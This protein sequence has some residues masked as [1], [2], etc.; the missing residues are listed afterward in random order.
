MPRLA[1]ATFVGCSLLPLAAHAVSLTD[2]LQLM[3][4]PQLVSDYRSRGL[5]LTLGDPAAQLEAV[6]MHSSG[7]Y[8]GVWTSNVDFGLNLKT[9]LEQD[10]YAGYFSQ[11]SDDISLDVGYL[12]YTYAKEGQLN[13]SEVYAVLKAY[14]F[15]FASYYSNDLKSYIGDDQDTL[16]TYLGYSQAL[17]GEVGLKL[18]YGRFDFKD[19]VFIAGNG[20]TRGDYH[21]WEAR[22]T[23]N[24][25]GLDWGVAYIDTDLSQNQCMSYYGYTDV[26]TATVVVS[27]S[28]TF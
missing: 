21:E 16:Y 7:A 2:N 23:R 10:Y 4:K 8:L 20:S 17:P 22:L 27:A 13:Q 5:S 18:R 15:E 6:L 25:V 28:K 3:L 1:L 14:G 24:V 12:K 26:C 11:L 9:R 19:D